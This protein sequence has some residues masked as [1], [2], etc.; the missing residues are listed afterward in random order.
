[1]RVCVEKVDVLGW[2]KSLHSS[3]ECLWPC[4]KHLFLHQSDHSSD[5]LY[6]CLARA[7]AAHLWV[8]RQGGLSYISFPDVTAT[9]GIC[10]N[11]I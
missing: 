6:F 3:E 2:N 11:E 1:M 5:G 7:I 10:P 9:V 4:N 8:F